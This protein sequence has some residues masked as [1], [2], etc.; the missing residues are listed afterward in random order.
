MEQNCEHAVLNIHRSKVGYLLFAEGRNDLLVSVGEV[1]A[2]WGLSAVR[3]RSQSRRSRG[4][5]TLIPP[6]PGTPAP[7]P[8]WRLK[9]GRTNKPALLGCLKLAGTSAS[10]LVAS[11][12]FTVF[13]TI[14]TSGV[15]YIL[16]VVTSDGFTGF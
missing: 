9:V 8:L 14:D 16:K 10:H 4:S 7:A 12:D 6:S 11:P 5:F 3:R 2:W 13:T 15:I 1:I